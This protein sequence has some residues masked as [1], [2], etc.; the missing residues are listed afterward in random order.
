MKHLLIINKN[1]DNL[2][3]SIET[4]LP[5]SF[6]HTTYLPIFKYI[7]NNFKYNHVLKS[8]F[9]LNSILEQYNSC[10][11]K[12]MVYDTRY[13]KL[14]Y[15]KAFIKEIEILSN[16][17]Y[18]RNDLVNVKIRDFFIPNYELDYIYDNIQSIESPYVIETFVTFLLSECVINKEILHFP[19]YY[20]SF[21]Y[22]EKDRKNKCNSI[23]K[24]VMEKMLDD[25]TYISYKKEELCEMKTIEKK[26]YEEKNDEE[27]KY[28]TNKYLKGYIFQILYSINFMW[29]KYNITHND[30]HINNIMFINTSLDNIEYI[31]DSKK[32]IIPTN[33]KLIK[34]ID[35]GRACVK[36]KNVD[37]SNSIF[38]K[39]GDCYNQYYLSNNTD[40]HLKSI[41]PRPIND[42]IMFLN[43]IYTRLDLDKHPD[44]ILFC[45]KYIKDINGN[46]YEFDN[47]SFDKYIQIAEIDWKFK[48]VEK[49]LNDK[50]FDEFVL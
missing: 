33:N 26:Y 13:N 45:E 28:K 6:A 24:L 1:Y 27:L 38:N 16:D 9:I 39:Q 12:I 36:Y 17:I 3:E 44:I 8:R 43:D 7:K 11:F 22:L 49:I 14:K 48:S 30:L 47:G 15:K 18:R 19:I 21:S 40:I 32:Y 2:I 41:K 25:F 42:I 29:K 10:N 35:F 46:S 5:Y 37:L 20:G 23:H 34:I 31:L 4:I 50:L